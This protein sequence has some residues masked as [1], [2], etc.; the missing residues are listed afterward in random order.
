MES[1]AYSRIPVYEETIDNIIGILNTKQLINIT[2]GKNKSFLTR[3][4][5]QQEE[6]YG[7]FAMD[8]DGNSDLELGL[9]IAYKEREHKKKTA[10]N[11][12]IYLS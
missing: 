7:I 12:I 4:S 11:Y 8:K 10:K 6:K 2:T 9:A 5:K 3:V 1:V